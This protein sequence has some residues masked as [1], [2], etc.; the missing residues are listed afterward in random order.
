MTEYVS[1][2]SSK[3]LPASKAHHCNYVEIMSNYVEIMSNYVEIISVNI[4]VIMCERC[5]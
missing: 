4:I 5:K 1:T 3:G 2:L